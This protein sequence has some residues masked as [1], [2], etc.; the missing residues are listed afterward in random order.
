M[1]EK[2]QRAAQGIDF[3]RDNGLF[4]HQILHRTHRMNDGRMVA[5][6]FTSYFRQGRRCQDFRQVHGNLAGAGNRTFAAF[7]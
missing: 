2:G 3:V 1:S 4:F 6:E 5:V 7:R